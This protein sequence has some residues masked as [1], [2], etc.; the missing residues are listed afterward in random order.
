MAELRRRALFAAVIW[1]GSLLLVACATT[2][3]PTTPEQNR[4]IRAAAEA[5][6]PEYP[7]VVRY[8]VDRF[9]QVIA[10]FREDQRV[11]VTDPFFGCIRAQLRTRS[12]LAT[13]ASRSTPAATRPTAPTLQLPP[14]VRVVRPGREVPPEWAAFSGRWQGRWDEQVADPTVLVV[15]E[16]TGTDAVIVVARRGAAGP[17]WVRDRARLMNGAITLQSGD[18]H[19]VYR[20]QPDGSLFATME[21]QGRIRRARLIRISDTRCSLAVPRVRW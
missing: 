13:P 3:P 11:P 16:L 8:E 4:R 5:C 18:R 1:A 9:G 21:H 6:L 20:V 2:S 19:F 14:D 12:P 15:E 7:A 10:Y 17:I